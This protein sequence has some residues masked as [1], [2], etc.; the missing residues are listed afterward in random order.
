MLLKPCTTC[1][2]GNE[3]DGY[4][5]CSR[6]AVYSHLSN[7]IQKKALEYYLEHEAVRVADKAVNEE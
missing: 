2:Y 7:C 3:K 1:S 6:E 5:H 4:S